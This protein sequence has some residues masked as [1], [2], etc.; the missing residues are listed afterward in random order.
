MRSGLLRQRISIISPVSTARST[1]GA[2][3][4]S[5]S[6]LLSD[7]W[8]EVVNVSAKENFKNDMRWA[9]T[10]KIFRIRY[11]TAAIGPKDFIVYGGENYSVQSV[12][13]I[14]E[15]NREYELIGRKT[16]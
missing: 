12:V 3:V 15:R 16:T 13:N 11:T 1:D 10:D 9:V 2:P 4:V 14:G 8:C 5:Y 6:T 7:A